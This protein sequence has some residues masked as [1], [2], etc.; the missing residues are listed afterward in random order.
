[1]R[2]LPPLRR[3]AARAALGFAVAV[4]G[5]AALPA[6]A[7]DWTVAG[8]S[9]G[10]VYCIAASPSHPEVLYAGTDRGV[11]RSEDGGAHWADA[12][13][14]LPVDRV[15]TIAV[16]AADSQTL[17]AGTLTPPGVPS[18]GIFKSA[19]GGRT[20]TVINE[21]LVD[22]VTAIAPLD[23][24]ALVIDP[25]H[26]GTLLA[27]TRFSEIFKST[28]GGTTWTPATFGGFD[29]GLETSAI[30]Y[31]PSNPA[32]VYAATSIGLLKSVDGG[33]SWTAYGDADVP[34]TSL[35]I[36]P[37]TPSTIYAGNATGVGVG[38]STDGGATW[39]AINGNLPVTD[40]AFPLVLAVAV[41]PGRPSRVLAATLGD[42]LF[43]TED[44]GATWTEMDAGLRSSAIAFLLF[45]TG[46]SS[47]VAAATLGAGV[48]RSV[49][50]GATWTASND[51]LNLSR[52]FALAADPG[53]AGTLYAGASDG[54]YRSSDSGASWLPAVGGLPPAP[55]GT[56]ALSSGSARP[57]LAGTLGAGVFAS[58]DGGANWTSSAQGLDDAFVGAIAV[59]PAN[60][61]I[62]YAGTAHPASV[63]SSQRV[64]RSAD[65]GFSWMVTSLDAGAGGIGVLA[66]DP[67]HPATIVAASPGATSYFVS[68]DGGATW[69]GATPASSCGDVFAAAFEA[70]GGA[71]LLG[72]SS[73]VCRSADG[74][75][76]WTAHA[77]AANATVQAL[78]A[79][80]TDPSLL[81]AGVAPSVT[82]G[83]GGVFRSADGGATWERV[84]V[85]LTEASVTSLVPDDGLGTFAVGIDGGGVA[86]LARSREGRQPVPPAAPRPGT[87]SLPPR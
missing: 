35:A 71:L 4:A 10:N 72:G 12:S 14:G 34:L 26:P 9:G 48:Y 52:V 16:D 42:G 58:A 65:G 40:S 84:G 29:V 25:S 83:T 2:S 49:D 32:T 73:G 82:G 5:P 13:T 7:G 79:D 50:D 44:G 64:Y 61:S 80:A 47:P 11:V 77:V 56:L 6:Q 36:D 87:R 33:D 31:D 59:D 70:T 55:V 51:G 27:G 41:D 18:D 43:A 28:D 74:G 54:V 63:G 76:T 3:F 23:V 22:P 17:Y 57:L 85:S 60:S 86:T 1:M 15:Q 69:S 38:K 45:P 24:A 78:A 75:A 20:W 68:R 67:S 19:D 53:A 62:V 37:S 39:N 81:W 21:G 30:L 46:S 8:P 66:I